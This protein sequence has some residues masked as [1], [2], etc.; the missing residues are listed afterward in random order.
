MESKPESGVS[1]PH[2]RVKNPCHG[3]SFPKLDE[4]ESWRPMGAV[5]DRPHWDKACGKQLQARRSAGKKPTIGQQVGTGVRVSW[6]SVKANWIP[7]TSRASAKSLP[8][9]EMAPFLP[10]WSK[11]Y[12]SLLGSKSFL[13]AFV[14]TVPLYSISSLYLIIC[15]PTVTRL[16]EK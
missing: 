13:R 11:R 3:T 9:V 4:S 10:S 2:T 5:E 1:T 14:S 16:A 15:F 8:A 6:L 7:K 12:L